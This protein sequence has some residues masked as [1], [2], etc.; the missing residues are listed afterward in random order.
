MKKIISLAVMTVMVLGCIEPAF[1]TSTSTPAITTSATVLGGL[2][3]SVVLHKNNSTG[4]VITAMDFGT[5]KDIG[6]G[7][8]RS[9]TT[10][11][12]GTGNVTAMISANSQSLPYTISQTGTT[13]SNGS[14]TLPSGALTVVPVY[15]SAD[16]GGAA[17]PSGAA[18]GTKGTWVGSRT[19]YTSEPGA[20]AIRTIQSVYSV[21]DDTAAGG[22]TGVPLNQAAGT[23]SGTVTIT[24]TA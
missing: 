3:L 23:Y 5:L 21:T 4:T 14:T 18:L 7:T 12:T 20:A 2:T 11:S 22:T 8:L 6:T 9:S 19:L 24:V 17:M 16:N 15:A 10:G 13:L 1:A